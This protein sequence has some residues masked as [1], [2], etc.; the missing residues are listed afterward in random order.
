M[1]EPLKVVF[2]IL[3]TYERHGWVHP[4]ILQYF[5]DL[6]FKEGFAYRVVPI[7]N[8]VPAAAGRNV[9]CKNFKNTDADWLCM[10]DND[11]EI[12]PTLLD[13]LK[14][15]PADAGIVVPAF[16][17]WTQADR[18]LTLC[19]GA[20]EGVLPTPGGP[21]K[22]HPGFYELTKAGTGVMFIRPSVLQAIPYPYFTYLYNEDAGMQGTE[23][24]EFC[25][26]A[27]ELGIKIYGNPNV[28]IGHYHSVEL[29][30]MWKWYESVYKLDTKSDSGAE[31]SSKDAASP[32]AP[33]TASA[34]PASAA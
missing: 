10:I 7:H 13:T 17:A 20:D 6:P 23:D 18:K 2:A 33:L 29:S 27:R 14:D 15:V 3:T 34:S 11:M 25:R 9:F 12:P 22:C 24:L 5:S 21:Q 28:V 26:R 16:Y 4:S 30:S 31:S 1:S 19:W 8:F 32:A